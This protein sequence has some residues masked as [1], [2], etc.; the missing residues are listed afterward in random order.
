MIC[1]AR[2]DRFARRTGLDY[3]ETVTEEE[4]AT[5]EPATSD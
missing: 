3:C 1:P 2:S 4:Q 5:R